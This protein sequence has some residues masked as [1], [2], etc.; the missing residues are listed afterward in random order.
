M[1]ELNITALSIGCWDGQIDESDQI[2]DQK[3]CNGIQIE[4]Y[5]LEAWVKKVQ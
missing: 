3:L 2:S 1:K 4:Y 5:D